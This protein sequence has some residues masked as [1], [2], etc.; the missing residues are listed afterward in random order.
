MKLAHILMGRLASLK[1]AEWAGR[2]LILQFQLEDWQA[3]A[4]RLD[5]P[6]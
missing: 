5:V 6:V 1:S 2:L 4:R 3:G